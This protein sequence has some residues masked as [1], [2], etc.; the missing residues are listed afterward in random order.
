M[1]QVQLT[2]E[3]EGNDDRCEPD[4]R[5]YIIRLI[6][7]ILLIAMGFSVLLANIDPSS[8]IKIKL[9][10]DIIECLVFIILTALLI[11][12]LWFLPEQEYHRQQLD[13]KPQI[14]PS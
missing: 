2:L 11:Y 8:F 13:P 10:F 3:N 14:L 6:M 12:N 7:L 1:N 5:F 4:K 9:Y